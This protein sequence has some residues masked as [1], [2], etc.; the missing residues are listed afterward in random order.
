MSEL[1]L[2]CGASRAKKF[3]VEGRADW[4]GLTTLDVSPAC[5]PDHVH[6]MAV[7]PLPF[8]DNSFDE[9]HAYE[10]LEHVGA[11]GD[12]RFFFAQWE[13]FWRILKP[14]GYFF[15]TVP[16]P[17]SPWAWGDPGHTRVLPKE[18][19]TFLSQAEYVRQVGVTPMA[20][21]RPVWRGDFE[22]VHLREAG[23]NLEFALRAIKPCT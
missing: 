3:C 5:K 1:L 20:D 15:G 16:L 23:D 9:I 12:W 22:L 2:G 14:D 10:C 19:F 8:A 11:Q 4:S 21:Y 18:C 7:L 6:D 17:A 13:D